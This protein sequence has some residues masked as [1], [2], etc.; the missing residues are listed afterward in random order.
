MPHSVPPFPDRDSAL[1]LDVDGTLLPIAGTPAQVRADAMQ[2]WLLHE[3]DQHLGGALALI[4]GRPLADLDRL[5]HPLRL[6]CAGQHGA[7]VR[8]Q[9]GHIRHAGGGAEIPLANLKRQ[10]MKHFGGA[11]G[12]LVEDKG[13]TL[14]V[15]Y[16]LVPHRREDIADTL[17]RLMAGAGEDLALQAGKMVYEIR[18]K[19]VDKGQ[20]IQALMEGPPFSGRKPIFLGDDVTDEDGF[21]T[22]NRLEGV[23]VK[24]GGGPTA[25]RHRLADAH[26]VRTWLQRCLTRLKTGNQKA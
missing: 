20:A 5:F 22:V 25:A 2:V 26:A 14:A 24:V 19:G 12:V 1:F 17:R 18:P 16:R 8:S 23:S 7:E 21:E 3:L 15:H 6:A 4:S 10:V 9:A 11:P 13:L